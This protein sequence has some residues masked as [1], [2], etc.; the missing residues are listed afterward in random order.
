MRGSHKHAGKQTFRDCRLS[1][2]QVDGAIA[3]AATNSLKLQPHLHSALILW[4]HV[5]PCGHRTC[6]VRGMGHA[7]WQAHQVD[8]AVAGAATHSLQL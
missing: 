6:M 8:G 4:S 5:W 1:M 3:G 7:I 2:H